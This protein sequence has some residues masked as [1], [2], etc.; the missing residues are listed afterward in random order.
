MGFASCATRRLKAWP[1]E[2]VAGAEGHPARV[3]VVA[4]E[5][6]AAAT[7]AVEVEAEGE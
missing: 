6:A 1:T 7:T 4:V 3:A 5:A 2:T